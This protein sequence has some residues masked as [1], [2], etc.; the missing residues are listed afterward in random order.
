MK[1]SALLRQKV[2]ATLLSAAA[3]SGSASE[4]L[5]LPQ[6]HGVLRSRYE[7][8]VDDPVEYRFQVRYAR[9]TLG[10]DIGQSIKYFIQTDLCDQGK[11]KILDVWSRINV[12]KG[13]YIQAGQFR[14]PFGV[15]T[16]Q[17]PVNYIFSNRSYLGKQMCNYRAVGAEMGY[18]VSSA[19]LLLECGVFNPRAI[20]DHCV[21][22][23]RVATSGKATYSPG[24]MIFSVGMASL[25]PDSVRAN[26]IDASAGF[27]KGRWKMRAE[28]MF[29]HYTGNAHPDA[30]SWVVWADYRFPIKAGIFNSMSVQGR[31]DGLTNHASLSSRPISAPGSP[32]RL[33]TNS[34]TRNRLTA[35]VTFSAWVTSRLSADIHANYEHIMYHSGH[36]PSPD[37]SSRALLELVVRF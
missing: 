22:Q 24:P 1:I 17:A 30:R 35:G 28:Y 37:E 8:T 34:P 13:L 14:M 7:M 6:I 11:M 19:P 12:T 9:L 33:A 26:L 36:T 5:T 16:F 29:E 3:L 21:W 27:S 4:N 2:V 15:E 10:G 20:G 32:I 31:Y 23:T 25:C 18:K